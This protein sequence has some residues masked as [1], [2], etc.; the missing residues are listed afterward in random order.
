MRCFKECHPNVY[1]IKIP[2]D[3]SIPKCPK[4][5]GN[6]RPNVLWFDESYN[7]KYYRSATVKEFC[8]DAGAVLVIGTALETSMARM[9]V[10]NA[11]EKDTLVVEVN[12]DP[13]CKKGHVLQVAEKSETALP[14]ILKGFNSKRKPSAASTQASES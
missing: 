7:E 14:E 1:K 8:K 5:S 13:C 10:Y 6:M 9:I 4:C 2:K 11:L 3:E 12:P